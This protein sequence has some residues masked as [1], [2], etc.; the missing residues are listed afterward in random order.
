MRSRRRGRGHDRLRKGRHGREGRHPLHD[1]R[2][3]AQRRDPARRLRRGLL[4]AG[5]VR[6]HVRERHARV[7]RRRHRGLLGHG[8]DP[9]ALRAVDRDP[10]DRRPLHDGSVPGRPRLPP[11][12]R[13]ARAARALRDIPAAR[14]PP[15]AAAQRAGAAGPCGACRCTSSSPAAR[16]RKGVSRASANPASRSPVPLGFGSLAGVRD[17]GR[18]LLSCLLSPPIPRC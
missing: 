15:R 2:G 5:R 14:R 7:R 10:A 12:G 3:L 1:D 9:R 13:R 16:S 4:R 18:H 17:G 11:A 8:A 6:D